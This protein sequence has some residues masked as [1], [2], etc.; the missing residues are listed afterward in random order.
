[1]GSVGTKVNTQ[2]FSVHLKPE[3]VGANYAK[4]DAYYKYSIQQNLTPSQAMQDEILSNGST[5]LEDE[6][7]T[8]IPRAR[9]GRKVIT[10]Y[11]NGKFYYTVKSGNKI[12]LKDGTIE[13]AANQI[14]MYYN[15]YL[16]S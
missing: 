15:K 4:L 3:L 11:R 2:D 8:K 6:W 7:T 1:M 12:L 13:Q 10:R 16:Q 5:K 9:E 14:A